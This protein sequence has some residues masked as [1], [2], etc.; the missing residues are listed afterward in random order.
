MNYVSGWM[1]REKVKRG[2]FCEEC[3]INYAAFGTDTACLPPGHYK[4]SDAATR[5]SDL[6][7]PSREHYKDITNLS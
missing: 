2:K 4:P 6:E 7:Q 3:F 5:S 1:G